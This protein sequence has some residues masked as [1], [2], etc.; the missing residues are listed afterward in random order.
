MTPPADT[1]VVEKTIRAAPDVVYAYLTESEKWIL[2]QGAAATLD[3][4]PGGLFAM[5]M[6]NGMRARGQF[7][8]LIPGRRVVFSW[9]WVDHPELP[10]GSSTVEIDLEPVDLGTRLV[11][12][13]RGLPSDEVPLHTLGWNHYIPRLAIVAS[14]DEPGPDLGPGG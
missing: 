3:A 4:T 10:P 11:L 6:G 8:E 13:H 1:I 5:T 2:W 14:G 9:G 12:R 7:V